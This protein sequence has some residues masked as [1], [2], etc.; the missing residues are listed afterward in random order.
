MLFLLLLS[1]TIAPPHTNLKLPQLI[2]AKLKPRTMIIQTI[3]IL[4]VTTETTAK[5]QKHKHQ[6]EQQQN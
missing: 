6:I 3:V 4:T 1:L 2:P 5:Q